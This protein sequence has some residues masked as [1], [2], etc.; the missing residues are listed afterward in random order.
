MIIVRGVKQLNQCSNHPV[1]TIG[2]FDGVHLGH[3]KIISL[4]IEQAKLRGGKSIALTFKP[5]PQAA[6]NPQ[7]EIQLLTT[8]PEKIEIFENLGVDITIEEPFSRE[9]STIEPEEFFNEVLL[10][11]LGAECIVVGYDFG[12]GKNRGGHL[13]VLKE[14]CKVAQV[15]LIVVPPMRLESEIVS[16]SRIRTYLLG[17]LVPEANRLLGRRFCYQGIVSHGEGRG[18]QLGFPTANLRPESKLTLPFGVYATASTFKEKTYPSITNIGVRPTF[19][20]G[21]STT[22]TEPLIE[23]HLLDQ[24]LDLY[25][26]RLEVSFIQRLRAE[27]KFSSIDAL[28]KQI[29]A[30]IEA[31]RIIHLE[32]N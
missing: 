27:Q 24:A 7:R 31:A 10:K 1:I 3:Q 28:K 23:T 14:L 6:L 13:D 5:H 26:H 16:S 20:E 18:H 17:G 29:Q 21:T 4:A 12:F 2:N 11:R 8:Y 9:F 32:S 15:E 19:Q 22:A 25:G 30:D